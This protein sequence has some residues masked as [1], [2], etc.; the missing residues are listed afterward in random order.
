MLLH[1]GS[2]PYLVISSSE[3]ARQALKTNDGALCTRPHSKGAKRISFNYTDSAFSPYG[4]HWRD[5][6]K[7]MVNEFLGAKRTK[8]FKNKLEVEMEGLITKGKIYKDK[9]F[10]GK[11]LNEILEATG[12]LMSDS[13]SEH[14]RPINRME[15]EIRENV[16]NGAIDTSTATIVWAMS[17][18]VKNPKIMEKLQDKIRSCVGRKSMVHESDIAKM[19]YLKIVVKETL[20][21]HP[22]PSFLIGREC[23]THCQIG[24]Y[25]VFPGTRVL[26]NSWRI[27]RDSRT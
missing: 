27:G 5:M 3:M 2:Q 6:R 16:H 23:V 13:F 20:R 17:E 15:S 18:I 9:V 21:L 8:I 14:Y 24:G 19:P 10:N 26:I 12:E 22:P 25:D 7:F 4:D 11:T 1:F